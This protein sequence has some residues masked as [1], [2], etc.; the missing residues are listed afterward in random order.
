MTRHEPDVA[1]FFDRPNGT[2]DYQ[3]LKAMTRQ[4]DQEAAGLLNATARGD[5]LSVG[6]V[7]DFFVWTEQIRA[8]TVLDLS[9]EMLNSYCPAGATRVEGDLYDVAFPPAAF[10]TVVMTLMLHHTPR[11]GWRDC[12]H[13]IRDAVDRAAQWLRPSGQLLI[14]EYCPH[15]LWSPVQRALLPVTRR[16]LAR[17][18]QPLVVMYTRRF[19]ERVLGERFGSVIARRVDPDGFDYWTWYPVFMS[20]RWLKMPLALYPKMH[21]ITATEPR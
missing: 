14:L 21:V 20:I 3:S 18:R 1:E 12:E 8:L 2:S 11:G 6:G 15:P 17:F 9:M 16:F 10:D 4:L 5:V 7:W 19:Y 13:R